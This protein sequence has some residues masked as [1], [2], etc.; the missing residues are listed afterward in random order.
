M[1]STHRASAHSD[2]V[3]I[4]FGTTVLM[5]TLG[6]VGRLPPAFVP[7][8]LLLL[9]LLA[10]VCGG[11][12]VAGRLTPRGWRGG[13]PVGI[14]VAAL[15]LLILGSLLTGDR[16]N[17]IVPS[18]LW[19]LPG[20]AIVST[21]LAT[22]GAW[23]GARKSPPPRERDWVHALAVVASGAT[24]LLIVVGGVVTGYG[25]GLA[26]VDWP[27]S[28]GY[29]MFLYPLSRMTGNVYYEHSHR[30]MGSLVGLTT[31][32][33]VVQLLRSED[34]R[35]IRFLGV[36]AL[37]MVVA[38]GILG[39]LRVTGR[40]TLSTSAE[41]T[42]PSITLAVVHGVLGQV[43]LGT[44]VSIA[45][46]T[47]PAWRRS[48]R[49]YPASSASTDQT[50]AILL[51]ALLVMQLVL[52]AIQRHMIRG[53]LMHITLACVV[54]LAAVGS[55]VRAWGLYHDQ[56]ILRRLGIA[57]LAGTAGQLV[58]GI[59]AAAVTGIW[60]RSVAAP[61]IQVLITTAHQ[62]LGA[63]LLALAVM[64]A[65]WCFRLLRQAPPVPHE[66]DSPAVG[67]REKVPAGTWGDPGR[68]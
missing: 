68:P 61:P 52:G 44:T 40:L 62:A 38:Q 45:V 55:G 5:W 6:Y 35:S 43:F 54:A 28:F 29:N 59:G 8:P 33:L 24:L 58:L 10:C 47:S 11:G 3:A 7:S 12:L 48:Q 15:N 1:T 4:A 34:R 67:L 18:A 26:V 23:L 22:A 42:S 17:Q 36:A 2:I 14:L 13:P 65:L 16:P 51:T 9:C 25:A 64:L 32:V 50:L 56:P 21:G 49:S 41:D 63:V 53:L 37:L 31:L 19:W 60:K 39:G 30:L 20:W 27:N 66:E 57:L 46:S